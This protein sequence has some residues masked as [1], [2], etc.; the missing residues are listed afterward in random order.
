MTKG[1]REEA[2][3]R[4]EQ[5][6]VR[7]AHSG[8]QQKAGAWVGNLGLFLHLSYKAYMNGQVALTML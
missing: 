5:G 2:P 7:L 3:D 4:S 1:K 8:H 6:A